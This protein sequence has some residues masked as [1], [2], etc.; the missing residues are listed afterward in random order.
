MKSMKAHGKDIA[1]LDRESHADMCR[2]AKKGGYLL[3][4]ISIIELVSLLLAASDSIATVSSMLHG[5]LC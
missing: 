5:S 2:I 3:R 4:S 1:T